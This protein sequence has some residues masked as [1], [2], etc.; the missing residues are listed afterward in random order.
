MAILDPRRNES[1]ASAL[2]Q[3]VTP[4]GQQWRRDLVPKI[5]PSA[6]FP[7]SLICE[8]ITDNALIIRAFI[9]S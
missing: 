5:I 4:Q 3:D 7:L 2:N 9:Q 1:V 8:Q 6:V